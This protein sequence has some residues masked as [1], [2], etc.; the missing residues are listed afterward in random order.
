M[1]EKAT[2]QGKIES[3]GIVENMLYERTKEKYQRL[4]IKAWSEQG[5]VGKER[6]GGEF[7]KN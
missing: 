1:H 7:S 2:I 5:N 3:R 6:V 4:K